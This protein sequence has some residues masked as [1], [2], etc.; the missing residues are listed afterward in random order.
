MS[1]AFYG[2][3]FAPDVRVVTPDSGWLGWVENH[4]YPIIQRGH[5]HHHLHNPFGLYDLRDRNMHIDQFE[6]ASCRGLSWL[7]NREAFA[8]AVEMVHEAGG[9]VRA[10]VGSPLVIP[11]T[12]RVDDL[13]RCVPGAGWIAD[14]VRFLRMLGLCD[15]FSLPTP[16]GR[17]QLLPRC[18][19]W[20][21]L[22][23]FYIS[24][25]VDARVDAIGFD[26]SPDFHPGD[27]MDH[28]VGQLIAAGIEVMIESWPLRGRTYPPVSWIIREQRYQRIRFDP[29]DDLP[30][31]MVD[32]NIYRLVPAHDSERGVEEINRINRIRT[33]H[34]QSPF[35]YNSLEIA[36]I[37]RSDGNIPLVRSRLL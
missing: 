31:E 8:E 34:G 37:V 1:I 7:A 28:L 9:T 35:P 30:V 5:P 10:Y 15:G 26:A 14:Q 36:D 17:I 16:F 4:A 3:Q 23:R 27:C 11:E 25:L 32:G 20:N 2:F 24:V 19:C 13:P 22:I 6:L 21:R 12:P 29:R 18:V 33:G